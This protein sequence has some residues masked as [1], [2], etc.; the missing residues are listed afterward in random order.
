MHIVVKIVAVVT[1][2]LILVYQN[3]IKHLMPIRV[4]GDMLYITSVK[5][6]FFLFVYALKVSSSNKM[7]VLKLD[8]ILS[9]ISIGI[10]VIIREMPFFGGWPIDVFYA[11]P[12]YNFFG[13]ILLLYFIYYDQQ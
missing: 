3:E 12:E 1:W 7:L 10:F 5:A 11:L 6:T 9:I 4:L 8:V 13:I 2:F